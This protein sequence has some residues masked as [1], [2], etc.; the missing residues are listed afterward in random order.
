M[1]ASS[2]L[3]LLPKDGNELYQQL[4]ELAPKLTDAQV[5]A[6]Y[7]AAYEEMKGRTAHQK[8]THSH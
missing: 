8:L 5:N 4:K 1:N 6:F 2:W 3:P 7:R